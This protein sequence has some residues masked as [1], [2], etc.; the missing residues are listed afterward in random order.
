MPEAVVGITLASHLAE[1]VLA[2]SHQFPF[3]IIAS[4]VFEKV[5]GSFAAAPTRQRL[6]VTAS[7]QV[8]A[9]A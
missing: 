8:A 6:D 1:A 4:H 5:G 9:K 7:A 2:A 3:A